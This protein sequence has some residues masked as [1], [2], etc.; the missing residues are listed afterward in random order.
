MSALESSSVLKPSP[1]PYF[2]DDASATPSLRVK[3]PAGWEMFIAEYGDLD[4]FG[5]VLLSVDRVSESSATSG[6]ETDSKGYS[7]VNF[8]AL[9]PE[10]SYG[11]DFF[12]IAEAAAATCFAF[13][14]SPFAAV[15][16]AAVLHETTLDGKTERKRIF[17]ALFLLVCYL[18]APQVACAGHT[19]AAFLFVALFFESLAAAAMACS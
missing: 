1:P 14:N 12:C 4:E 15:A 3:L 9:V 8:D 6:I 5:L 13:P 18:C 19:A 17:K 16:T 11:V 7:S 10:M 2:G